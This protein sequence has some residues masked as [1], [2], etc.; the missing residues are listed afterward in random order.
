MLKE[1]F[2]LTGKVALVPG[3]T[4]GIGLAIGDAFEECGARVIRHNTKVCDLADPS[5]ID[6]FFDRLEA[7]GSLPD[8]VVANASIQAKIHRLSKYYGSDQWYDDRAVDDAGKLPA[9]L[10]R[11]VLTEDLIY[12]VLV[13]NRENAIR[14]LE[15][16]TEIL[17]RL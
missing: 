11:G 6:A 12:D 14:M 5:A 8:I 15:L 10:K 9:D 1:K 4:R 16:G 3:S 17:K 7:E 2:D 13:G